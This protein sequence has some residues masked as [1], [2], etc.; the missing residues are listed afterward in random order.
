METTAEQNFLDFSIQKLCQYSS[1]IGK[2]LALLDDSQIW[3]RGSANENAIGNLVLHLCGNVRQ[4]IAIIDGRSDDRVRERE[5]SA[6]GGV[7]RTELLSTLRATVENA[8]AV[9]SELPGE[10]LRREVITGEFRQTILESIYHMET[11]F[12]LHSGQIY[13]ATKR[14]TGADL[15]FYK[16]PAPVEHA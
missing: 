3:W 14:L 4:R 5:F 7:S 15:N 10:R 2:C 8:V 12:A 16:P 6:V 9:M 1:E 11:H 13:S